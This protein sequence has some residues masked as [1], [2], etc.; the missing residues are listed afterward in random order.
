M[1]WM[2]ITNIF[3]LLD[4]FYVYSMMN[5][6]GTILE[7]CIHTICYTYMYNVNHELSWLNLQG[8]EIY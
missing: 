7:G 6:L 2:N 5:V 1:M 4:T 8:H 3:N